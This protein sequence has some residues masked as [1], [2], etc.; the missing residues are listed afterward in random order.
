MVLMVS[1]GASEAI[2]YVALKYFLGKSIM[3]RSRPG[4]DAFL[5]LL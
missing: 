2:V 4:W 3:V 5:G 1:Y